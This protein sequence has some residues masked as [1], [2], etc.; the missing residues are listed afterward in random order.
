MLAIKKGEVSGQFKMTCCIIT[1]HPEEITAW[2]A[3]VLWA[4]GYD[5]EARNAYRI[6]VCVLRTHLRR[7]QEGDCR[8]TLRYFLNKQAVRMRSG[9]SWLGIG[10]CGGVL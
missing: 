9:W 3:G 7:D 2:E 5:G 10:S 8:I 1:G 4:C 6:F